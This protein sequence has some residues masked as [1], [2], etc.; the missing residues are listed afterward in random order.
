MGL[1]IDGIARVYTTVMIIFEGVPNFHALLANFPAFI[2]TFLGG[3]LAHSII[4]W[5]SMI[6][7]GTI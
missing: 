6:K 5:I 4:H 1:Q 3:A 2:S 7:M